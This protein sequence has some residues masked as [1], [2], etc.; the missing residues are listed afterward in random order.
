MPASS[1][2]VLIVEEDAAVRDSLRFAL[3]IEGLE[4]RTYADLQIFLLE[5]ELPQAGCVVLDERPSVTD[6]FGLV[7]HLRAQDMHLP[8]VLITEAA[9]WWD[10]KSARLSGVHLVQSTPVDSE[11]LV[12]S[13]LEALA[14]ARQSAKGTPT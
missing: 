14:A 12:A 4:V 6:S 10:A 3:E 2:T 8:V 1:G 13:I 11:A 7:S 9:S 5:E